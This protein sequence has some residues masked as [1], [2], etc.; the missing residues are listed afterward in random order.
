MPCIMQQLI[1]VGITRG[2]KT[3]FSDY[4]YVISYISNEDKRFA[5]KRRQ[6]LRIIDVLK[7]QAILYSD[8]HCFTHSL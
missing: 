1:Y 7:H 6:N 8:I 3:C 2:R 5:V 4:N